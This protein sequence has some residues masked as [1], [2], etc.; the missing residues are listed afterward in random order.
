M[1]IFSPKK[2]IPLILAN[3]TLSLSFNDKIMDELKKNLKPP[4]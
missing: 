3:S 4:L 1:F 2:H